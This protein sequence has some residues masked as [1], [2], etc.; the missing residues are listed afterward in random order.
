MDKEKLEGLTNPHITK[1]SRSVKPKP[2]IP[3]EFSNLYPSQQRALNQL[4]DW[5][6]SEELECTLCGYAGTGKTYILRYFLDNIVDKSFTITA[7][8]H[9]AL[10]VL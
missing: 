4:S 5:Y 8:T 9:K 7:P 2:A 6:N 10:R 1:N 3:S